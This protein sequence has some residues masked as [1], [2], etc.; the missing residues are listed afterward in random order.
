MKF[1]RFHPNHW[2]AGDYQIDRW[3][4]HDRYGVHL[5]YAATYRG[6]P[7]GYDPPET[8]ADA[9]RL[10]DQHAELADLA[11]ARRLGE[12]GKPGGV[13]GRQRKAPPPREAG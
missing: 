12:Q 2:R 9:K 1:D 10:C 11:A 5:Q 7:L 13:R 4:A 6:D 3:R 8:L